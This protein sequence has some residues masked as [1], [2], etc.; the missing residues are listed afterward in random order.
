MSDL[1][2]DLRQIMHQNGGIIGDFAKAELL[3]DAE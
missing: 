3:R 2:P 1:P